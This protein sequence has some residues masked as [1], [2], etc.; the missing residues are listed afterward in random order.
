MGLYL[1]GGGGAYIRN[2]IFVAKYMGLHVY[3]VFYGIELRSK[4]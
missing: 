3:L 1:G 2:N 4:C